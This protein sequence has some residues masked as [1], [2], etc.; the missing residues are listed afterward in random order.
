MQKTLSK[1][2][3]AIQYLCK[4]DSCLAQ[5]I[6]MIGPITYSTHG[7]NPY[8]FIV[9]EIIEQMLSIKASKKIYD[10]LENICDGSI[11]PTN[12]NQLTDEQLRG[13]VPL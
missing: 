4:T 1:N 10:R 9:H 8:A 6:Q 5:A 3:P 2:T 13:T 7:N 11:T 12:I